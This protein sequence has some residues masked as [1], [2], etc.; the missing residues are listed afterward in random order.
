MEYYRQG[1]IWPVKPIKFFEASHIEDAF[2]YMQ[3]G[4]H[5]G[6]IVVK[7]PEDPVELP[8]T[9]AKKTLLLRSDVS[10]LLVG[11]LGGLGKAISNWMVEQG[12]KNLIYLSRSAEDSTHKTF[13]S[14]LRAQGCSVQLFKG[15]VSRLQ[16]V[17]KAVQ[18]ASKPIAGMIQMSMQ[19]KVH[20]VHPMF[21]EAAN[22]PVGSS[23][24]ANHCRGLGTGPVP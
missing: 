13:V 16:D 9:L 19:L 7:M 12:A 5:I 8:A 10:Y 2:R 4:Q 17:K 23:F 22:L 6:K 18:N 11:G 21:V 15:N 20:M 24:G 1:L 3:K 14:E